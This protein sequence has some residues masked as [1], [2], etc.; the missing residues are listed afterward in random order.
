MGNN[1]LRI[2][3]LSPREFP[4]DLWSTCCCSFCGLLSTY[5]QAIKQE[6]DVE[7]EKKAGKSNWKAAIG[8][9]PLISFVSSYLKDEE[10]T[11]NDLWQVHSLL[12]LLLMKLFVGE[13]FPSPPDGVNK[14]PAWPD[15][16][17]ALKMQQNLPIVLKSSI[18]GCLFHDSG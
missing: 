6:A 15:G 14:C 9:S 13:S 12:M 17:I 4:Q 2:S 8:T 11:L 1:F 10:R 7:A 16:D 5:L 3:F 18:S